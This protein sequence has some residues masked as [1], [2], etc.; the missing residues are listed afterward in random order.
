M[1]HPL[2]PMRCTFEAIAEDQPGV[3][4]QRKFAQFWPGYRRWFLRDGSRGRPGYLAC[5]KAMRTHMPELVP[6]WESLVDLAGGGDVEARFLSMWSP[7]PYISGC[8]QAIFLPPVGGPGATAALLRNYDFAPALL[9]GTWLASRWAGPRVVAMLDCL[10][11]ALD[12][13][14]EHG[15]AASLAFGGRHAVGDG[16]GIPLVLRYV[17]ECAS[18]V[19]EAVQ[20]LQRV[21]VH[22]SYTISLLDRACRSATVFVAP[23]RP[24]EIVARRSV[25][26]LQHGVEWVAHANA[27]RA[28]LR[29]NTLETALRAAADHRDV[30]RALLRPPLFQ[31]S[32]ARGYGTLY[33]AA[34]HPDDASVELLWTESAWRQ[35]CMSFT[36]G[37]RTIEFRSGNADMALRPIEPMQR[38]SLN[39][40][41]TF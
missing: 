8:A 20:I 39:D 2:P 28:E 13:V 14:N 19:D 27:T 29:A 36:P 40:V 32:Y 1:T 21:P 31:T 35:S 6:T 30:V 4:W 7:P 17:L 10:W 3:Q 11:G 22:M 12:G 34:Y 18:N 26:N 33:T 37:V 15:L 23:D 9:E 41:G 5:R 24:T 16:F 38:W 25:S